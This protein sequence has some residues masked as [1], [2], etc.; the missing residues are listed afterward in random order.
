MRIFITLLLIAA[1]SA[2]HLDAKDRHVHPWDNLRQL[3]SGQ[4]IEIQEVSGHSEKGAF[5]GSSEESVT[6]QTRRQNLVVSRTRIATIKLRRRHALRDALIG[7]GIGAGAGAGIGWGI[8]SGVGSQSGGDFNNLQ[9]VI[10]GVVAGV[11]ALAGAVVGSI[12][13]NRHATV[14]ASP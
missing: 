9:P 10:V 7:A 1:F 5:T 3:T 2:F 4:S 8:G 12:I 13:G 14:Y 6:I 11:G